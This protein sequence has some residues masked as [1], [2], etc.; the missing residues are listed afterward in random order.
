[1]P[2]DSPWILR[3]QR[4]LA[5]IPSVI[6]R[7]YKRGYRHRRDHPPLRYRIAVHAVP[8]QRGRRNPVQAWY[9]IS[10]ET[11]R[12]VENAADV[13]PGVDTGRGWLFPEPGYGSGNLWLEPRPGCR[14]RYCFIFSPK[15][16]TSPS[17][18]GDH[19]VL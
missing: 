12:R 8:C 9:H 18:Q 16:E 17:S 3:A 19:V 1:M 6:L 2:P 7:L 4:L 11:V 14:L 13:P 15:P 5:E 10:A